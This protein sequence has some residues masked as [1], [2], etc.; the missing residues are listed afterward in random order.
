MGVHVIDLAGR[1]R[2]PMEIGT[3]PGGDAAFDEVLRRWERIV[4]FTEDFVRG[5]L[6]R[7]GRGRWRR[8]GAADKKEEYGGM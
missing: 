7:D 4:P 1:G 6:R 2:L 3:V 5:S 8:G